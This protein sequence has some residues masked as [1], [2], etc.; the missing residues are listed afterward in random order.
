MRKKFESFGDEIEA[1]SHAELNQRIP[2][3]SIF[4]RIMPA[5]KLRIVRAL[6]ADGEVVA[7][8]GDGVNDRPRSK[9][10]TSAS[11]WAAAARTWHAKPPR[12][13]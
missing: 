2:A 13:R 7:M 1:M 10:P 11:P 4:A 8:T 5:Q 9:P 3:V 12:W 6:K